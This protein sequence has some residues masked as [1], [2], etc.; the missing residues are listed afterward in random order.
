MTGSASQ[1]LIPVENEVRE[2]DAKLLLS[3][4]AAER[5]YP[6]LFGS[7]AFVHYKV[8]SAPRGVYMAKSMRR[9]SDRMFAIMTQLGHEIV[10]FDEE[11]LVRKPDAEYYRERVSSKALGLV[12]HLIAWGED[13]AR[14]FRQ[15]PDYSGTPVHIVGNPRIDMMRPEFR[16]YYEEE[17]Y[18]ISERYGDFVLINSNFGEFNHFV[19]HMSNALKMAKGEAVEGATDYLIARAKFRYEIFQQFQTALVEMAEALPDVNFVFRPHPTERHEL[20]KELTRHLDNVSVVNQGSV[21]PWL[22]ASTAMVSNG[23]T[24]TVESRLLDVPAINYQPTTSDVYDDPLPMALGHQCYQL[25]SLIEMVREASKGGLSTRDDDISRKCIAQHLH[26]VT[27]RHAADL[28]LDLFDRVGYGDGPPPK[29]NSLRFAQGFAATQLRNVQK[30]FAMRRKDHRNS[31]AYH[32]HRFPEITAA[33]LQE[34][35][36]R[37]SKLSGRFDRVVVEADGPFTFQIRQRG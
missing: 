34:K 37:L 23:C 14:V 29:P 12:S 30:N 22:M 10:C 9:L 16:G 5:G 1:L 24:T 3:C 35:V 25:E 28:T 4:V 18:K 6:V 13:D 8:A 33:Q 2:L 20:W 17:R 7:R 31:M 27:G 36:G 32:L 26:A 19:S 21:L 15:H 11:A